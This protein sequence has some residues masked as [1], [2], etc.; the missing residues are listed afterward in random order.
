MWELDYKESWAQKNWCFWTAVLEKTLESP[1]DCKDIKWVNA[2]GNQPWIFIWRT[3]AEASILSATW[4]EELIHWKRPW[5]WERLKAGGEGDDRGW[6]GWMVSPT[7][8]T[9]AGKLWEMVKDRKALWAAVHWGCR[10]WTWLS[11]WTTKINELSSHEKIGRN[12]KCLLFSERSQSGKVNYCMTPTIWHSEKG[13]TMDT[14]AG[15][16]R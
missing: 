7:Q 5:C 6:D 16:R 9:W 12:F 14:K 15:G 4:C 11:D 10:V 13:K 8:W 2:K 1:L 3:D